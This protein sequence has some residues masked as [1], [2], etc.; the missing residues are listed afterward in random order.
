[1]IMK[2]TLPSLERFFVGLEFPATKESILSHARAL[3]ADDTILTMFT[4]I[5]NTN[6]SSADELRE[7]IDRNMPVELEELQRETADTPMDNDPTEGDTDLDPEEA[8]SDEEELL[9]R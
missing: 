7:A 4:M 6:Y 2:N 3:G 9:G 5:P 8:R 1:M